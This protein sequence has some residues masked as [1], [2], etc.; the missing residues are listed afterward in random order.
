VT[1]PLHQLP[2]GDGPSSTRRASSHR[3][4]SQ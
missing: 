3:R 4:R 2:Q 1:H